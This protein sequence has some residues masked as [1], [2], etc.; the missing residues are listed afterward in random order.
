M[1]VLNIKFVN[2]LDNCQVCSISHDCGDQYS[3]SHVC[4]YELSN[5]FKETELCP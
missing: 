1:Q 2:L 3:K 5:F 4:F